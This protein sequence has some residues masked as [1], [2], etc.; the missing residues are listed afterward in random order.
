MGCREHIADLTP[1]CSKLQQHPVARDP[2]LAP[3]TAACAAD[4]VTHHDRRDCPVYELRT[5]DDNFR[6]TLRA[7]KPGAPNV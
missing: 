1:P 7:K 5:R 2:A 4:R 6:C 3:H